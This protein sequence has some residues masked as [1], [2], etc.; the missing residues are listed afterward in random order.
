MNEAVA[1]RAAVKR[2]AAVRDVV[3]IGASAGGFSVLLDL[4][5]RLPAEFPASVLIVLHV[6]AH[7]SVLPELLNRRSSLPVMHARSGEPL[8][9]GRIYVAPPDHHMLVEEGAIRLTRGAKEHHARPAIDP[10][11]R[12]VAIDCGARVVG[13]VLSGRLDDGTAGLQAIQQ[14]GGLVIVQDP[15]D[16]EQP[17]MP[18][19]ACAHVAVDH[20]VPRARLA[21]TLI[22]V[23]GQPVSAAHAVP[24]IPDPI[25]C[26]QRV[27]TGTGDDP[28]EDLNAIGKL[29][30]FGCPDCNGVLW[31]ITGS[32][33]RRYRC[34]TGH[35][36]SLRSLEHTQA[37]NT[38]KALWS[39]VRALQEREELL[40]TMAAASRH[41]DDA[42]EGERLET[43]AD[44]IARHAEALQELVTAA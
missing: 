28:M 35:G 5:A 14:C 44:D 8:Q 23:A 10:L 1:L 6:G 40:R 32:T 9:P 3:V 31:E 27:S 19:S 34:H 16:A 17:S 22:A 12:S 15:A 26:E 36:F 20:C 18:A 42:S 41:A 38:D 24:A 33:P 13:V 4:V 11:F 37:I 2:A 25:V 21:E 43:E 29:S 7:P 39:A 30:T